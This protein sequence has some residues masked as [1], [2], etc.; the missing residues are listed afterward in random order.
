VPRILIILSLLT[1]VAAM[2]ARWWFWWRMREQGRRVE[3]D[4]SVGEMLEMLNVP[5]GRTEPRKDAAALG[6][7]LREAGLVLM[8][9]DGLAQAKRRRLGWWNLRVLPALVALIAV[10][11]V[12]SKWAPVQWVVGLGMLV[13]A[14]HVATRIAGLEIEMQ[15]VKRGWDELQKRGK[16]RR[17]DDEEAVLRCARASVWE[18]VLPW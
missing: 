18:T 11:S 7:A 9:R 17:R 12:I 1:L 4:I 10:F 15:A 16:F 13:I 8:E 2:I 3:C 5:A 14:G 6:S